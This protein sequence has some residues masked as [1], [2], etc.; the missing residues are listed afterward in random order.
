MGRILSKIQKNTIILFLSVVFILV[1]GSFAY[2][3]E[4][5]WYS[6]LRQ[7]KVL[8]TTREEFEKLFDYPRVIETSQGKTYKT[9]KYKLKSGELSVNYS[10][11]KCIE[12]N[13]EAGYNVSRD[14]V[15]RL[16]LNLNKEIKI[17]KLGLDL[18]NFE[19]RENTDLVGIFTYGNEDIGERHLGTS[20]TISEIGI[21]PSKAQENLKCK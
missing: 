1:M 15:V 18:S 12:T 8:I 17:S 3:K 11:G 14:V 16:Y 21:F 4:P 20:E 6:K 13:T 9:V 7:I 19:K 5:Q 10:L 2:G